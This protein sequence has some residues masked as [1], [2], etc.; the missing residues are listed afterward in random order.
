MAR[1]LK[2]PLLKD[3]PCDECDDQDGPRCWCEK[4][5]QAEAVVL[6]AHK[7]L[8][9]IEQTEGLKTIPPRT[10]NWFAA[11]LA[12]ALDNLIHEPGTRFNDE[13]FVIR[14]NCIHEGWK[15]I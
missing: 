14:A 13:E 12:D 11:E 4:Y 1:S 2:K 10:F 5:V 6:L 7:F 15:V 8:E 3:S 9:D